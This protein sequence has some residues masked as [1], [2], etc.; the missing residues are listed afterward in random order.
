MSAESHPDLIVL[1][2]DT[3]EIVLAVEIKLQGLDA[4]QESS[5]LARMEKYLT[6]IR[7]PVGVLISWPSTYVMTGPTTP[8]FGTGYQRKK[9]ST[10]ALLGLAQPPLTGGEAE[11]AAFAWVSRLTT[12]APLALPKDAQALPVVRDYLVPAVAGGR[13]YS[14]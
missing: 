14:S 1:A 11:A 3:P 9:V 13:V 10:S 6:S 5:E 12:A 4:A 7:C 8:P 2:P